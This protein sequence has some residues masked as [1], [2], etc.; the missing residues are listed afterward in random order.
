LGAKARSRRP[1][2][3]KF[4]EIILGTDEDAIRVSYLALP[5]LFGACV[6][7]IG[8]SITTVFFFHLSAEVEQEETAFLVWNYVHPRGKEG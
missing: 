6:C 7:E 2:R 4:D 3:E 8:R 1:S 5:E